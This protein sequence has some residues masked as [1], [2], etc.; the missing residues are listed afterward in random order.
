M[1]RRTRTGREP[2]H[3][4]SNEHL[5]RTQFVTV[6]N[7]SDS[8][9]TLSRYC[10]YDC[11]PLYLRWSFWIP[12]N[13]SAVNHLDFDDFGYLVA[14]GSQ[15]DKQALVAESDVFR[16]PRKL[17]LKF[18]RYMRSGGSRLRVCL[19]DRKHCLKTFGLV[20]EERGWAESEV[21]LDPETLPS[22]LKNQHLK[23]LIRFLVVF[24]L[25]TYVKNV[26]YCVS[27]NNFLPNISRYLSTRTLVKTECRNNIFLSPDLS[28]S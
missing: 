18:H 24:H 22:S 2:S 20:M 9:Q 16:L 27:S 19:A 7:I 3:G 6:Y 28:N 25:C 10:N 21:Q 4:R 17:T 15:Q 12:K 13:E 5:R 11:T 14:E 8:K 1:V 23:V 26:D